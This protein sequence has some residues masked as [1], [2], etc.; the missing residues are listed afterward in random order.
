MPNPPRFNIGDLVRPRTT[1]RR[2]AGIRIGV[3]VDVTHV[4]GLSKYE[5]DYYAYAVH[6]MASDVVSVGWADH[7]LEPL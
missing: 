6:F 7:S 4:G 2:K 3:I 5:A 1:R